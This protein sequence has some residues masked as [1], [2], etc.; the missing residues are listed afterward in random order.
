MGETVTV[1]RN[2]ESVDPVTLKTV[3]TRTVH[4][5]SPETGQS[6]GIGS[7]TSPAGAVSDRNAVGQSFAAEAR[8]LSLPVDTSTLVR[9]DDLVIVESSLSNDGLRGRQ[10]RVTG[11][12]EAA[13]TT[14]NRFTL[15]QI[16]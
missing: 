11:R 7:V 16:S 12:P 15:E 3:T 6:A 1:F 4:Y 2:V 14:A 13:G 8:I 10:Y 5:P 9:T